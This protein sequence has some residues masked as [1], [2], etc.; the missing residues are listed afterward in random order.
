ME[1]VKKYSV[2]GVNISAVNIADAGHSIDSLIKGKKKKYVCVVP[3]S[4]IMVCQDNDD[5]KDIV[6]KA[7][8]ATPD[9][10]PVVWLG[11]LKGH[12]NVRRT[13]GPDLML[14]LCDKGQSRGYRHYFY[15]ATAQVCEKLEKRLK[16]RFPRMNVVGKYSP[17]LSDECVVE[18]PDVMDRINQAGP[19]IL[20]VALGSPKQDFWMH[21]HRDKLEVPVMIGVG[22][23]FDFL[24]GEKKQAPKWMQKAGLEWFFRLL[25]EPRRLWKRYLIGNSRFLFLILRDFIY[26]GLNRKK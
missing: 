13:Y 3:V 1:P 14:Y 4:V 15:G 22:A 12:K 18:S 16:E 23:A 21:K 2:L 25:C 19:D 5:Y 7:Q 26:K 20:W 11:R 17:P 6:N 24:S 8:L 9:G 10:M